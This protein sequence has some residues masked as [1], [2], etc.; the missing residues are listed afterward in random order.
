M[1]HLA[2]DRVAVESCLSCGGLYF[3]A[4][5]LEDG[6]KI[7][8]IIG[9]NQGQLTYCYEQRLRQNPSLSGRLEVEWA[10]RQGRATGV[11]VFVNTTG[12]DAFAKCI[13]GKV[14]RWRFDGIDTEGD[15]VS[16]PFVFSPKN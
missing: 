9:R 11:S 7:R 12:D 16:A 14:A 4:G 1:V 2:T 10:I 8:N 15:M 13:E 6:D 5:E 3:D